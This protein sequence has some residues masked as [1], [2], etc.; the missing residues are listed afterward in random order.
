MK[1]V[2]LLNILFL[3]LGYIIPF[4]FLN[5]VKG[6]IR[7]LEKI[8]PFAYSVIFV[9]SLI[10][11]FINWRDKN[12]KKLVRLSLVVLAILGTIFSSVVLWLLFSFRNGISF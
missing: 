3:F 2:N 10:I 6:D 9:T 4:Y 11:F 5:S 12:N 8:Q 1:K 7:Y